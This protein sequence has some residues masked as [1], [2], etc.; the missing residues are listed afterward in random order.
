MI[1]VLEDIGWWT[2]A[3]IGANVVWWACDILTRAFKGEL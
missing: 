2:L 3:I 1:H